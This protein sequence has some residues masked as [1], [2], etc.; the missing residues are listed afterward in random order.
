MVCLHWSCSRQQLSVSAKTPARGEQDRVRLLARLI[1]QPE[2]SPWAVEKA[3]ASWVV[4]RQ[5]CLDRLID[6]GS[7]RENV[8]SSGLDA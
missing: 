1:S 8:G 4:Y 3:P 7:I 6:S 2:I 5:K